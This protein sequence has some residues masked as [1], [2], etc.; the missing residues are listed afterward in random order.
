M[1]RFEPGSVYGDGGFESFWVHGYRMRVI[2]I[3]C[4]EVWKEISNYLDNDVEPELRARIEAHLRYVPTA[5]R[6]SME[7]AMS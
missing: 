7:P 5:P 4:L 1:L 3:N 6:F 2:E